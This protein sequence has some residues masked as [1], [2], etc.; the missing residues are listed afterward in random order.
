MLDFP[1]S[2]L[3]KEPR[4]SPEA[5]FEDCTN[6]PMFCDV[7][8]AIARFMAPALGHA[9]IYIPL[10]ILGHIDHRMVRDAARQI[11]AES[12]VPGALSGLIYYEDLPYAAFAT[13]YHIKNLTKAVI[14]PTARSYDVSL[15]DL[16]GRKST[17]VQAYASQVTPFVL[18]T[19]EAHAASMSRDGLPHSERLWIEDGTSS[20]RS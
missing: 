3:R 12:D 16:W 19:L 14:S 8:S 2:A 20:A 6:H 17:A 13:E 5:A 11:A 18:S 10:G 15:K 4:G 7:K 9:S 1:D